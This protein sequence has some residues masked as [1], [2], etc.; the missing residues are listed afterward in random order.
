LGKVTLEQIHLPSASPSGGNWLLSIGQ[1][2]FSCV[3]L[4]QNITTSITATMTMIVI[5]A[6]TAP[7]II[8]ALEDPDPPSSSTTN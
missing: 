3:L 1:L 8:A 2:F 5:A 7:P 4:T 6:P